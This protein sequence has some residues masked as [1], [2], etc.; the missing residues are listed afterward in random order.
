M[1]Y[2]NIDIQSIVFKKDHNW[3]LKKAKEWVRKSLFVPIKKPHETK[4]QIRFRLKPPKDYNKYITYKT[5]KGIYLIIASVRPT[6]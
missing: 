6:K 3:T 4:S 2:A 5:S 1:P